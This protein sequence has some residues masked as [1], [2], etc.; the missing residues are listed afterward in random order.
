MDKV[1][2]VYLGAQWQVSHYFHEIKLGDVDRIHGYEAR[3]IEGNIPKHAI[4]SVSHLN[5][6]LLQVHELSCFCKFYLD[7]GDGPCDN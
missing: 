7:G 3:T 1:H 6:T 2:L 5:K 4:Q